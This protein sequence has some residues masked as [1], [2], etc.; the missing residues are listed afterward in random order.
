M[1]N[2]NTLKEAAKKQ[3]LTIKQLAELVEMSETGFHQAIANRTLKAEVI[4]SL[5]V[6]L[7]RNVSEFFTMEANH[8]RVIN[9]IQHGEGNT[10]GINSIYV[11][12]SLNKEPDPNV[13]QLQLKISSL[14]KQLE[15]QSQLLASKDEQ[16]RLLQTV[17][18]MSKS[19]R[20]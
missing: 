2:V 19:K 13:E 3:G 20:P 17:L 8:P 15:L 14:E 1:V 18:E 11:S 16:L 5:A 4:E 7:G 12:H 10:F 6:H 9:N